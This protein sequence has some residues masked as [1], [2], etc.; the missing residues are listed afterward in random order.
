MDSF[1][2]VQA[3]APRLLVTAVDAESRVGK[4]ILTPRLFPTLPP[5]L[6]GRVLRGAWIIAAQ[7]DGWRAGKTHGE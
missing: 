6:F 2:P 7:L 3:D 1:S 5:R 4:P